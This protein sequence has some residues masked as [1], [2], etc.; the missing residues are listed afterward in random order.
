MT[1]NELKKEFEAL[2]FAS[3]EPLPTERVCEILECKAKQVESAAEKLNEDYAQ[4]DSALSLIKINDSW[5][6]TTK[7][8][9]AVNIRKMLEIQRNTPLSQA[10]FEVLAVV[11]YNQPV[12]R[13]YI[14]QVRGVDCG[15]T[16]NLLLER[17]LIE[18]SGRLQAPGRPV[19]YKTTQNFLRTFGISSVEELPELPDIG[20]DNEDQL[21]IQSA[22]DIYLAKNGKG[23]SN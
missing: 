7:P 5:Q 11:A 23:S 21:K 15:Y 19:L 6:L 12:T 16:I 3:G 22:I 1:L 9:F 17:G 20:R 2:V 10:A 13:A 14:E 4:R 8:E 18:N